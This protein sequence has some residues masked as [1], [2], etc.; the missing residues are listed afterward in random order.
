[1]KIV[2]ISDTTFLNM[3][4]VINIER[5]KEE[6]DWYKLLFFTSDGKVHES[7]SMKFIYFI[8][9]LFK[10]NEPDTF[11]DITGQLKQDNDSER[12]KTPK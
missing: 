3:D 5:V 10:L 7:K 2:R 1:M 8:E 4:F 6:V 11:I 9:A 12:D